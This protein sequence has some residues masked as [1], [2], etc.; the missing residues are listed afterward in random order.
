MSSFARWPLEVRFFSQDVYDAWLHWNDS[1]VDEINTGVKVIL[2]LKQPVEPLDVHETLNNAQMKRRMRQQAIG[3]G[4]IE[5][6]D[7]GYGNMKDHLE[8]SLFLLAESWLKACAVCNKAI[9]SPV[10]TVLVC[11]QRNCRATSH[12]AC[13]A[14]KF[15]HDTEQQVESVLPT[16]GK[17]PLCKSELQWIDLVKEMSLRVRGEAEVAKLMKQPRVRKT[18]VLNGKKASATDFAVWIPNEEIDEDHNHSLEDEFLET[19]NE[20]DDLLPD[21]WQC[22]EDNSDGMS[23]SSAISEV[24]NYWDPTGPTERIDPAPRLEFV[25]EDSGWDDASVLG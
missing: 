19:E 4:G 18:K 13:L 16:T 9:D 22:Q 3:K 20:V 11:P 6:L 25:I 12:L 15:L 17:C 24:S 7:I 21:D 5:G 10:A 14:Q 8:K 1:V 23:V 2:D